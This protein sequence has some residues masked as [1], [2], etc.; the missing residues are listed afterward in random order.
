[1]NLF[2]TSIFRYY[3][4]YAGSSLPHMAWL[5]DSE[6]ESLRPGTGK[7]F[8][9]FLADGTERVVEDKTRIYVQYTM[10]GEQR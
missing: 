3:E 10:E 5:G 1:M 8:R 2:T 6:I 4:R 9:V 7:L